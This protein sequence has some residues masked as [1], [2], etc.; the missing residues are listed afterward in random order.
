MVVNYIKMR[1]FFWYGLN[2][3]FKNHLYIA[4]RHLLKRKGY[5]L[6]NI[7]GLAL[8]GAALLLAIVLISIASPFFRQLTGLPV[9]TVLPFGYWQ[10]FLTLFI[11]G[12]FLSGLYP[13]FVLSRYRPVSVL[14]GLFKNSAGGLLLRKGLMVGQFATSIMLIA[15]TIIVFRQVAYMRSQHL[16]ANI[17]RTL[18]LNGAAA[19][20]DTAYRLSLASFK[21]EM[22]QLPEVKGFTASSA[23]MGLEIL[24]CTNWHPMQD[25]K[26]GWATIFQLAVDYDFVPEYGLK[27]VAGRNFSK[28]FPAEKKNNNL[29]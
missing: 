25:A 17:D 26:R 13:A 16:G 4:F 28:N 14:K 6:L 9:G 8:N 18:V 22:Q 12:S 20:T 3:M 23:V 1:H 11:T 21:N 7:A 2:A 27:M 29:N 15:G 24:W 19:P 5:A 10:G